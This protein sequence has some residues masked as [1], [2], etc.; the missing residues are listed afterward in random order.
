MSISDKPEHWFSQF[1][2]GVL[3]ILCGIAV[4]WILFGYEA[5]PDHSLKVP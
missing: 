5:S 2:A 4:Y 3:C 1:I